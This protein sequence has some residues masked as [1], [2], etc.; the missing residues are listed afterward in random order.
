MI[1]KG[2]VNDV[3]K[4]NIKGQMIFIARLLGAVA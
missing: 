1:R 2:Q 4:G 3:S